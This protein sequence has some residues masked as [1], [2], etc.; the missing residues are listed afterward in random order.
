MVLQG[1]IRKF[2]AITIF[3]VV[4]VVSTSV[5]HASEDKQSTII[6]LDA[7]ASMANRLGDGTRL[8]AAKRAVTKIVK[9]ASQHAPDHQ[10]GLVSFYDGCW[11]DLMVRPAPLLN[12]K[13][14]LLSQVASLQTREY[15][16]TPIAKSLEIAAGL[17][18]GEKGSV[19]L[20]S[21]GQES[22]DEVLDLCALATRLKNE[23]ISFKVNLIGLALSKKQK[24]ALLCIAE[25]TGGVFLTADD[26]KALQSVLGIVAKQ[27]IQETV[28]RCTD[29]RGGFIHFWCPDE[30]Q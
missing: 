17:L 21:D 22:C 6:V 25:N 10:V 19:I 7:S 23:N 9:E 12:A 8:D 18:N 26:S 16:H 29:N 13:T 15:G 1:C 5:S 3:A 28:P 30:S 14:H 2:F 24:S 27:A 4:L 11:V 20:V